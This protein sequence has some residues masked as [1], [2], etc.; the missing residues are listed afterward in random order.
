MRLFILLFGF[1]KRSNKDIFMRSHGQK[2]WIYIILSAAV[3]LLISWIDNRPNWDDTGILAGMIFIASAFLGYIYP[4]RAWVWAL[5]LSAW[6]PL[7]G[8]ASSQNYE[9]LLALLPGFLG[10]YLGA[11]FSK[12]FARRKI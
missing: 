10:A 3:G 2:I 9:T 7:Y 8:I 12:I 11:M 5:T 1:R 6:I 4:K